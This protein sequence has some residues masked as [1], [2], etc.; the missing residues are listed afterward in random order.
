LSIALELSTTAL[1]EVVFVGY[2]VQ[3]KESVV[4]AISQTTG[5]VIIQGTQG[6]D[7][8]NALT[9]ALPGLITIKTSGIPGGSGEDDDYTHMLIRGMK[10][11]NNAAPLVLVDGVERPLHDVNPYEI[12]NISVL[13]DASATAVFGVKGANGVILINT[14]RGREGKAQLS[15]DYLST[16]KTISKVT[17]R[18]GSYQANLMKNYAILNEVPINETPWQ[19][20]VPNQWLEY[21]ENKTY[22]DYLPD[23]N[24]KDEFTKDYTWDHSVN[25]NL[26]GG[27]KKIKYFGA[28]SYLHEGDIVNISDMGQGY[29]PNFLFDRV[30]F[31]SNMDFDFTRTTRFS[32]NLSGYHSIAQRPSGNKWAAW[33]AMYSTPPDIYPVQ[34]S[35]GVYGE[36]EAWERFKNGILAFNYSGYR[37]E[38]TTNINTDF[39]LDQKLDF[40][41]KGLSANARLSYDNTGSSSGPNVTGHSLHSKWIAPEIVDEITPGM[42]EEEIKLLEE[43]YTTWNYPQTTGEDNFDWYQLPNEYGTEY[44]SS[45]VYRSLFYQLSL[46]YA[47]DFGRHS[48]TALA[49]VN[50]QERAIGDHFPSYREDWV[51]RVTYSF[52]RRYLLE[53]NGAY[54]GSEK[55]SK[56]Y[57]FGFFPSM[58]VGWVVSN[59]RFFDRFK[60]VFS[61]LKIRYSDGQVG[62]DEGIAR[63]LYVGSW[64]AYPYTD[65]P[66]NYG[67]TEIYRFGSPYL[68]NAYPLRYEGVIPNPDIQWETSRKRDLGIEAGFFSNRLRFLFDYFT[69]ERT[70]IF[71][72]GVN[73]AVPDF[74]GATPVAANLGRVNMKGWE[75][76]GHF[77]HTTAKGFNFWASLS[78]SYAIDKI[79]DAAEPEFKPAYQKDAGYQIGQPRVILTQ[80]T[81]SSMRTWNDVYNTVGGENNRDLLP[82]DFRRVDFNSDGVIDANDRAPH[83]YP[84]RPQYSYAPSAGLSYKGLSANI[85]FYGVYNIEGGMQ[86]YLGSFSQQFSTVYP[87]DI[88]Q[89]YS[90]ELNNIENAVSPALRFTTSDAGGYVEQSRAYLRLQHAEITYTLATSWLRKAGLSNLRFILSGDNLWLL[91]EMYEDFDAPR[92]T[93]QSDRRRPYPVLKRVN[94]GIGFTFQ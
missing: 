86:S 14:L 92:V 77:S 85:R 47:R 46:N 27:T 44:A 28:L 16:V 54:N 41:T 13:K 67:S 75:F 22:P 30:N 26:T 48:V 18:E 88:E 69:E 39:M 83:G 35:D 53:F 23:V 70:N 32:A 94:F 50:R 76:E 1:E 63:W 59:E 64:I 15:F 55:F 60:P 29:S 93:H 21:Y 20:I 42:T 74:F 73:R 62:S 25:M 68:Q 82:G 37:K 80:G 19:Y 79:I 31:R 84:P 65:D 45:T 43:K 36:N 3:K 52:D 6:G 40:I 51:G 87:W 10:T 2:G 5:E 89:A 78:W 72:A 91:S 56:E 9:G 49:L 12:D 66:G 61:N 33:Y 57:R 38:K 17:E 81:H 24:W 4:G 90:I 7:L 71:I 8:G 34:Y 11:W 58:A